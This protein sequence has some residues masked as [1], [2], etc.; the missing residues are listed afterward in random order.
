M[1]RV[2][3]GASGSRRSAPFEQRR[4]LKLLTMAGH[5]N[6]RYGRSDS[7]D[8]ED[9]PVNGALVAT[10]ASAGVALDH[11]MRM[12]V[13]HVQ[14]KCT[15]HSEVAVASRRSVSPRQRGLRQRLGG[16][17]SGWGGRQCD[18]WTGSMGYRCL[19]DMEMEQP[20]GRRRSPASWGG[21][22]ETLRLRGASDGCEDAFGRNSRSK[23]E[24]VS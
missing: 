18:G 23:G 19:R 15:P 13:S 16:E 2:D 11:L 14:K 10:L 1:S 22:V 4:T 6:A 5:P 17:D 20:D 12:D 8:D 21:V 9:A 7:T 24:V 3:E